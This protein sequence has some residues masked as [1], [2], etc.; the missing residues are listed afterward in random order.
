MAVV[1]PRGDV[2]YVV[3]E[4]GVVNLFGKSFQERAMAMISI[5]HP[6]FRDELFFEAKQMGFLSAGRELKQSIHGVY[7]LDLEETVEIEDKLITIRP[8][9]PVD[10]RSIQEHFYNQKKSDIISRFFHEKKSFV[11]KEVE[12]MSQIDYIK[13]LTL[14]AV[15][16]EMGF[17]SVIAM[18]E[19]LLDEAKNIAEVA[20]SV[21]REYQNKGIGRRLMRKLAEAA[22]EN[23]ISGFMA[24]TSPQNQ[25]M[26]RL[27]KSLPYKTTT[28]FDGDVL[29]LTC[30]FDE[31]E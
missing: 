18:G 19:Y 28:V 7:P 21:N 9:K 6:D 29:S 25:A 30:R 27:F 11:R 23:G 10:E 31:L 13:D 22:R 20:F 12:G 1:V 26:I 15:I 16:G 24:Y 5:A 17:G 14:V 8:A 2:Q 3:T 4:Y